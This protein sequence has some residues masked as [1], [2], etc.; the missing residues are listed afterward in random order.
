MLNEM[1]LE[2]STRMYWELSSV[3]NGRMEEVVETGVAIEWCARMS[4]TMR[5]TLAIQRRTYNLLQEIIEG[6]SKPLE[7]A[8]ILPFAKPVKKARRS[9]K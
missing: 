4:N 7:H 9:S 1:L 3:W 2:S 8:A 5:P 6:T